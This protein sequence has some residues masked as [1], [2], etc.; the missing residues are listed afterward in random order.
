MIPDNSWPLVHPLEY[1]LSLREGATPLDFSVLAE[2]EDLE[3]VFSKE[4]AEASSLSA[5]HRTRATPPWSNIS[6]LMIG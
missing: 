4:E 3:H 6:P 1:V 5:P 2:G